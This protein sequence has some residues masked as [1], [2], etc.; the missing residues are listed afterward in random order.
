MENLNRL[1]QQEKNM[2]LEERRLFAQC[3]LGA[4]SV[5]VTTEIWEHCLASAGSCEGWRKEQ[6]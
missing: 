5:A 4:L 1:W 3:L 6:R 2:T